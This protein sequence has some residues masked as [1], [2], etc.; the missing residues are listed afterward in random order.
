MSENILALGWHKSGFRTLEVVDWIKS[1]V[2]NWEKAVNSSDILSDG[3]VGPLCM[4]F[5][6][7]RGLG[8]GYIFDTPSI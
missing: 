7:V 4:T 6:M 5:E 3:S 8:L 1:W 2:R